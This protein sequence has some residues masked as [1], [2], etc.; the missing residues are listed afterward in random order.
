MT[1]RCPDTTKMKKV[2]GREQ[3]S[4]I[5]GLTNLIEHYENRD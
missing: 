2:L 4:L 3:V 1:R 5:E